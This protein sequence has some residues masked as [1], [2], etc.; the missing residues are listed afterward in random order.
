VKSLTASKF[1][2]KM[3]LS[4]DFA[5][6]T[7]MASGLHSLG[8]VVVRIPGKH[9]MMVSVQLNV[10]NENDELTGRLLSDTDAGLHG[11]LNNERNSFSSDNSLIKPAKKAWPAVKYVIPDY[12]HLFR[13]M[14][15]SAPKPT[16]VQ[17]EMLMQCVLRSN[18]LVVESSMAELGKTDSGK[19]LLAKYFNDSEPGSDLRQMALSKRASTRQHP[20]DDKCACAETYNAKLKRD[21]ARGCGAVSSLAKAEMGS[22]QALMKI[23][24]EWAALLRRD[25]NATLPS[26]VDRMQG[27]EDRARSSKQAVLVNGPGEIYAVSDNKRELSNVVDLKVCEQFEPARK[28]KDY[29]SYESLPRGRQALRGKLSLRSRHSLQ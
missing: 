18:P 1:H 20:Q 11:A 4:G 5:H 16:K 26:F 23:H 14:T 15:V 12:E 8:L 2:Y 24:G 17:K 29:A 3:K 13:E 25:Q 9:V 6:M 27:S 19:K 22:W 7:V 21:G 28:Y 10:H